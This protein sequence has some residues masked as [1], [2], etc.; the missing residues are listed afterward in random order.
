MRREE[1]FSFEITEWEY[2]YIRNGYR[3]QIGA[4]APSVLIENNLVDLADLTS[5]FQDLPITVKSEK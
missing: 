1:D 3:I 5:K 4:S 2:I